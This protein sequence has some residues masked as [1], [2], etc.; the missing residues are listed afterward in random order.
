MVGDATEQTEQGPHEDPAFPVLEL[1]AIS[2]SQEGGDVL[3]Q[4]LGLVRERG[5]GCL[6]RTAPAS[7]HPAALP[8]LSM[9]EGG[10]SVGAEV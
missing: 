5:S 3:D 1:V 10:V 6:A 4:E 2:H 8:P 9:V 7:S